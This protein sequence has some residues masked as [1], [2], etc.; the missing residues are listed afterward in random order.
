MAEERKII[1]KKKIIL[2]IA[3]REKD[4]KEKIL[5]F[6]VQIHHRRSFYFLFFRQA[7]TNKTTHVCCIYVFSNKIIR[8]WCNEKL[9]N[10]NGESL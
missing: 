8:N 9:I 3:S 5:S 1:I 7:N 4:V 6:Y 2:Y 10:S